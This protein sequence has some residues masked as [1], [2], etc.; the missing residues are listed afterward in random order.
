VVS[1]A[2]SSGVISGV[3]SGQ[4]A[5]EASVPGG[6]AVTIPVTVA[7]APFAL[8]RSAVALA[9]GTTDTVIASVPAQGGRRLRGE[10]LIWRVHDSRSGGFAIEP[11]RAVCGWHRAR[12]R[13][14]LQ[15]GASMVASAGVLFRAARSLSLSHPGPHFARSKWLPTPPTVP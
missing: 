11:K 13:G 12:G 15:S 3:A 10:D 2:D 5:V 7:L 6:V 8:D 4:A 14:L 9:P 1:V